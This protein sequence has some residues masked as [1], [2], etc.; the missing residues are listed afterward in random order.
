MT[1]L[2]EKRDLILENERRFADLLGREVLA[3]PKMNIWMIL[4]PF[5]LIYHIYQARRVADGRKVFIRNYLRSR[6]RA[7]EEGLRFVEKGTAPVIETMPD[8]SDLPEP[9]RKPF[10]EFIIFLT[11]HYKDLLRSDGTDMESLIRSTY[12]NR[13]NYL[14]FLQRL[15]QA[16]KAL[17]E[18][19]RP[20]I[21]GAGVDE[22]L[23]TMETVSQRLRREYAS[24]VFA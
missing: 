13:M 21:T 23:E 2:L 12:K 3:T 9:A 14:L 18:A 6:E 20:H 1:S 4:I 11:G 5:I 7:L 22:V 10:R 15:N 24:A 19:L 8:G 17:N 16:E